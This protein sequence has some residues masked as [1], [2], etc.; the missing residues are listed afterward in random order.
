[1]ILTSAIENHTNCVR[2]SENKALK[3]EKQEHIPIENT[4]MT[5]NRTQRKKKGSY[6]EVT[7]NLEE[8]KVN[9]SGEEKISSTQQR[10]NI[11]ENHKSGNVNFSDIYQ[12]L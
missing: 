12:D 9:G 5:D 10:V 1:M 2:F 6:A 4:W 8:V 7:C 3:L 11:L